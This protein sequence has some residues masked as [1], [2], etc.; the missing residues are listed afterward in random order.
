MDKIEYRNRE[1]SRLIDI[2]EDTDFIRDQYQVRADA[3]AAKYGEV[4]EIDTRY[5]S[6]KVWNTCN[7]VLTTYAKLINDDAIDGTDLTDRLKDCGETLEFLSQ[8]EEGVNS[9]LSLLGAA[10]SYQI[11]GMKANAIC[12]A[13]KLDKRVREDHPLRQRELEGNFLDSLI[14]F[15]SSDI[16]RMRR[17]SER[18]NDILRD[19]QEDLGDTSIEEISLDNVE[20]KTGFAYISE[21][22][23]KYARYCLSGDI[24]SIEDS[25]E[26][27][28]K[29]SKHFSEVGHY[30][31]DTITKQIT[32]ALEKF[33]ERSTWR[34]IKAASEDLGQSKIWQFYL[35]NLASENSITEFWPSQ[36][37]AIDEGVLTYD[38]SFLIQM[39][40]SAGKTLVAELSILSALTQDNET[41]CLYIA[42]YRALSSEVRNKLSGRLGDVGF[43]VADLVGGFEYDSFDDYLLDETDVLVATPEKIDLLLRTQRHFFQNVSNIVVDEGHLVGDAAKLGENLNRPTLGRGAQL[44]LLIAR[45]RRLLE[46]PRFLFL[47]AVMPDVNAAEFGNWLSRDG[48]AADTISV[49]DE[50]RPARLVLTKFEWVSDDN[51][52]L[53]FV[54]L[55]E[56]PSGRKPFVPYFLKREQLETGD[57]T[58]TGRKEKRSWPKN[59]DNKVQ[60]TAMVASKFAQSGPT[61]IFAAEKRQIEW[62]TDNLI[63]LLTWLEASGKSPTPSLTHSEEP[64]LDSYR[65]AR[66]WLSDDHPLMKAL[67]H[68]VGVH[69]G[70]LPDPVRNAVEYDFKSERIDILI[71]TTTLGQGVNLPIRNVIFYETDFKYLEDGELVTDRIP[72]RDFWNI[73]GRAGRAGEETEGKAVFVCQSSK[74]KEKLKY[75]LEEEYEEV[76]SELYDILYYLIDERI[77]SDDLLHY[78]D[79]SLLSLIA[80]EV[81]STDEL[82]EIES[83]IGES[84]V[85]VQA[86]RDNLDL[87]NLTSLMKQNAKFVARRVPNNTKRRVFSSTGMR[88]STCEQMEEAV[89]E[90]ISTLSRDALEQL[91]GVET[92]DYD[93]LNTAFDASQGVKEISQSRQELSFDNEYAL[94]ESWISGHR[95]TDIRDRVDLSSVDTDINVYISKF[96]K[97]SFPWFANGFVS[98]AAYKLSTNPGDLEV[99][100]MRKEIPR[101]WQYL[102]SFIK[103]GVETLPAC[104]ACSLGVESRQTAQ[105]VSELYDNERDGVLTESERNFADFSSW[106]SNL[107]NRAVRNLENDSYGLR[108]LYDARNSI[109]GASEH[110]QFIQN[111]GTELTGS[112]V[113]M[114]QFDSVDLVLELA[115]GDQLQLEL[116]PEE[117]VDPEAIL[118]SAH[119]Q[120]I[121]YLDRK[122][123]RILSTEMDV[124]RKVNASV[125]HVFQRTPTVD[126]PTLVIR[127]YMEDPIFAQ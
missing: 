87:A 115:P 22:A 21:F 18:I 16:S 46:N 126:D 55:E 96:L 72:V 71:S 19:Y 114:N 5:N 67:K 120:R 15:L 44:E 13:R 94:I 1:L 4:S 28:Q 39:P 24:S 62:L 14:A 118:V 37:K 127:I 20:E 125:E 25:I 6:R 53:E 103:Y 121:G 50:A 63:E 84:L 45:L 38:E 61:L 93:L 105:K 73:C 99:A 97:Y 41:K 29:S 8:I 68:G 3:N 56:L 7:Y 108:Q 48:D 2:V 52:E 43:R 89:E 42:P 91:R 119:G 80:E 60:T 27:I 106:F 10:L 78:F 36:L 109:T 100:E 49:S 75:Y 122:N 113:G 40:T 70:D 79:S 59:M 83:I 101:P 110:R 95:I 66:D 81:V 57:L 65:V 86:A 92:C 74:D 123:A 34:N 11:A 88:V 117:V 51:G 112:V 17:S 102:S 116:S 111:D 9:E 33:Y 26:S 85:G 58:P 54:E 69:H 82:D 76:I 32:T 77:S 12:L 47:S 104:W 64:D 98:I 23:S 30:R 31:I 124:G 35:R 107:S 90:Y